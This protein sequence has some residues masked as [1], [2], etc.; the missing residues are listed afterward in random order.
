[1]WLEVVERDL[2]GDHFACAKRVPARAGTGPI[3]IAMVRE[4]ECVDGFMSVLGI[5]YCW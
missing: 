1:M 3:N 4:G 2:A 5:P